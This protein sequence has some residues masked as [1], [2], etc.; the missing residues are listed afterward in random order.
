MRSDYWAAN[1]W[2]DN[3]FDWRYWP[4]GEQLLSVG[5]SEHAYLTEPGRADWSE[6]DMAVAEHLWLDTAIAEIIDEE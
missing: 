4:E 5:D 1:Y 2:Q 3:Y 6:P